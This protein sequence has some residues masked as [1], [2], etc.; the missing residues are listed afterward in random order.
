[1]EGEVYLN[2][3]GN[4]G[5]ATAGTGDVLCGM[6]ASFLGQGLDPLE[7]AIA[8]VWLHG[9]AG[10]YAAEEKG[11]AGLVATDIIDMIP[12]VIEEHLM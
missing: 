12:E 5:M 1:P 9:T 6:I 10:D 4:P 8:A 7:A 3:S 2:T 11:E